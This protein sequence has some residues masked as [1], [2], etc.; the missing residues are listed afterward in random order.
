M[1]AGTSPQA[2]KTASGPYTGDRESPRGDTVDRLKS[3]L[4]DS[5]LALVVIL[6]ALSVLTGIAVLAYVA[7]M[8][9]R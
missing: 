9:M 4:S 7:G 8:V 2:D 5:V 6:L 1:D 3:W